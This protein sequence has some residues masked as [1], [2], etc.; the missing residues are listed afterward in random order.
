MVCDVIE[1][2]WGVSGENRGSVSIAMSDRIREA[3][4]ILRDFLFARVYILAASGEETNKARDILTFL[5]DY[6]K[7]HEDKLPV[8][9]LTYKGDTERRVVDYIAGMTDQYA[10]RLAEDIKS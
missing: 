7:Q 8:E 10:Q 2:S 6:F 5:Y 4:S 1:F 3:A 9:Y